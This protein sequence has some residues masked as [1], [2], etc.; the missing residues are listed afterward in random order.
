MCKVAVISGKYEPKVDDRTETVK[1]ARQPEVHVFDLELTG[2]M[3]VCRSRFCT[4]K[5][6][7]YIIYIYYT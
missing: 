7:L 2:G 5:L 1:R 3:Y 6:Y 4:P